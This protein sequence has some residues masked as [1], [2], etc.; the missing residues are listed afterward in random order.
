MNEAMSLQLPATSVYD[1]AIVGGGL[2]GLGLAEALACHDFSVCV[3]EARSPGVAAESSYDDRTLVVGAASRNFWRHL[4]VWRRVAEE[5][6]SIRQV[7]VS[8]PGRFGSAL[9]DADRLGVDALAHV[10]EARALGLALLR[11]VTANSRIRYIS[12]ARYQGFKRMDHGSIVQFVAADGSECEIRASL[13]VAAD[14]ARSSVREQLGLTAHVYDYKKTALVCNITPAKPHH[15]RAYERLTADGPLAVLPFRARRCGLVWSLPTE[16]ARELLRADEP[17]F[18]QAVQ[19][20]FGWRLGRI[21]RVGRRSSYP[22]YRIE[23]PRQIAPGMVLMGN[24]AHT[25]APVSAQG[26]NLAVRDMAQLVEELVKAR[27]AGLSLGD[28][29]VLLKYQR[30][31]RR[32]QQATMKYTDDLMRWFALPRFPVP[33]LRTLAVLVVDGLEPVKQRLLRHGSG[34]RQAVPPLLQPPLSWS[35]GAVTCAVGNLECDS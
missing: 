21:E 24:A 20:A 23:V 35:S 15:G 8:Q 25:V 32:D 4:G 17:S 19:M 1:V 9:F 29:S 18:L 7:H 28:E 3:L 16:Q 6:E 11:Q 14:G 5:A 22:L 10:V 13:L 31:R 26:L 2:V 30:A 34:F 33:F 12:Q 27:S